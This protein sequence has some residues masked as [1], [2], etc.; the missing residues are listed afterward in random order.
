MSLI[1][2]GVPECTGSIAEAANDMHE[3]INNRITIV[4]RPRR[5]RSIMAITLSVP[6]QNRKCE[7]L[8]VISIYILPSTDATCDISHDLSA[9]FDLYKS[10]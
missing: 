7:K 10:N 6:I 5:Q 4:D 2:T 1:E 3:E 9:R 8:F